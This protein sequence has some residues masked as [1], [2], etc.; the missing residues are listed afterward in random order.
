[1]LP[2]T[3]GA[4]FVAGLTMVLL[5]HGC[6][7]GINPDESRL[8]D[9]APIARDAGAVV[10]ADG[11]SCPTGL[12]QCSGRCVDPSS[13]V[14][15][16]G[17]CDV[18]CGLGVACISGRCVCAPGDPSCG[19]VGNPDGC[20]GVRCG[21]AQYCVSDRCLCRPGLT[22]VRGRCVDLQSDP[23]HCGTPGRVC[24]DVC[25]GGTCQTR[26][27]PDQRECDGACVTLAIEP[28]HCGGC[29]QACDRD[30]LC[31][32]GNCRSY[33]GTLNCSACAGDFSQCCNYGV[34]LV[35]ADADACP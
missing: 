21:D 20:G 14:A 34:G 32:A 2:L 33:R 23:D 10:L 30:E 18:A 27:R 19:G 5:L 11:G 28:L 15:H 9:G 16:C 25:A 13:D 6:T 35:C 4:A 29:G 7:A 12:I 22:E 31:V 17:G 1:M 24:P 3:F 26:C 8:G